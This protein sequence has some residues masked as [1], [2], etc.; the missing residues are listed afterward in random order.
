MAIANKIIPN[1]FFNIAI[2]AFPNIFSIK[3]VDFLKK[4]IPYPINIL[5]SFKFLLTDINVNKISIVIINKHKS[6]LKKVMNLL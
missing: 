1:T 5:I 3:T 2:P 6:L 4:S